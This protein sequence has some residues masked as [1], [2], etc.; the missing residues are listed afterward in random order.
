MRILVTGGAGYIGSHTARA[1]ARNGHEVLV[2][3]NLSTG[4]R[5]LADG[6]EFVAGSLAEREKLL[7]CLRN[8]DGV[9]H[10]AAC[11]DVAE[12]LRNPRKYYENNVLGGL[13]LLAATTE[14]KVPFFVFSSSC[15]VYGL[16]SKVPIS[17]IEK[18]RPINPYGATKLAFEQAL[19]AYASAYGFR[20][21]SLRYFNAAGADRDGQIGEWHQPETHLIPR[22][23]W[24][25]AGGWKEMEIYG[26]DY[27]TPDRT[28]IRDYVHVSDLA[29]AHVLA[30][31]YLVNGGQS[32]ALN[33]GSCTGYSVLEVLTCVEQVMG[34][35]IS[36]RICARRIGDPPVLV[37]DSRQARRV[38]DWQPTRTLHDIVRSAWIWMKNLQQKVPGLEMKDSCE[39]LHR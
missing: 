7:S 1:L 32:V 27:P 4:H 8:V 18:C 5:F 16:P 15:A 39:L 37:A 36:K 20:F 33:L 35:F 30:L 19:K 10:F 28:C 12:S 3:D 31:Q 11:A 21:V 34:T 2:Y 6:F 9:F 24:V 17:E 22:A 29:E 38:L 25:A 14:A 13:S 23:L 26:A